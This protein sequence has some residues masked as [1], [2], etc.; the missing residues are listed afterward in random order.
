MAK[1]K[2]EYLLAGHHR[3]G[4]F[5]RIEFYYCPVRSYSWAIQTHGEAKYFPSMKD[6]V[7]YAKKN[8]L[9]RAEDLPTIID[10]LKD[11]ERMIDNRYFAEKTEIP[12][13][14][15]FSLREIR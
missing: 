14:K 5:K 4:L 11:M 3:A 12:E 6:C 13:D 9:I 2:P 8:G 7:G 1:V 10:N 15:A